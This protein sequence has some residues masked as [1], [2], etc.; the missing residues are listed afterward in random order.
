M[1]YNS[2]YT[3]EQ[4]DEAVAKTAT[5][6]TGKEDVANKAKDFSTVD[7]THFPTTKAVD[8]FVADKT[9]PKANN[10]GYYEAMRV[11]TADNLTA[12]GTATLET[13]PTTARQAGGTNAIE[14]GTAS[15]KSIHGKSWEVR[16]P[17]NLRKFTN[18]AVDT[19]ELYSAC[20]YGWEEKTWKGET[21]KL[22]GIAI[23][24]PKYLNAIVD[25][26]NC[27]ALEIDH[28]GR[29]KD[30][31]IWRGTDAR[32]ANKKVLLRENVVQ[33]DASVVGGLVVQDCQLIDLTTM[34]GAGNEPATPDE[35]AK[36]LGYTTIDEVPYIPYTE[37]EFWH[38]T[39]EG[40]KAVDT[41]GKAS[42]RKWS[43]VMQTYF[44]DGLKSAGTAYDEIT[45][46]KAV[47]RIGS[48]AYTSADDS[49][50]NV[51][52]DG[53]TTLYPLATPEEY[54]YD[55]LNLTYKVGNGGTEE[56]VVPEGKNSTPLVA[57][58]VYPIDAV[59]TI[60]ANKSGLASLEARVAAL[61]AKL[62]ETTNYEEI[63][64]ESDE[65]GD[66]G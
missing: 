32:N 8:D 62:T 30:I 6:A 64:D 58:I 45:P 7:D 52:T 12:R 27:K 18:A 11:G 4:I 46:T 48:R 66:I 63:G 24:S 49:D 61:E 43:G 51:L 55:E 20:L 38:T 5:L 23:S 60:Q 9:A 47:K 10:D 65:T 41:E 56:A 28:S 17:V 42:E 29:T 15:I 39:A 21:Y 22:Y 16:Q 44:P 40:I 2:K 1:A 54:P 25:T 57:E 50:S 59:G 3:G 36:R 31:V 14:D 19:Y 53:T 26:K 35:F 37:G 13:I 34:F 33:S